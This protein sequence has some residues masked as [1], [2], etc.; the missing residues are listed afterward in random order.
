MIIR[1]PEI[2]KLDKTSLNK[3]D[4]NTKFRVTRSEF[5]DIVWGMSEYPDSAE[6]MKWAKKY[7]LQYF[8]LYAYLIIYIAVGDEFSGITFYTKQEREDMLNGNKRN[9]KKFK[10]ISEIL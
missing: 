8:E 1:I 10:T 4:L 2:R 9:R 3:Y 7:K 6:I 5:Q